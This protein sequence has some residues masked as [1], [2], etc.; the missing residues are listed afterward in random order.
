MEIMNKR[1]KPTSLL[2]ASSWL[3]I[4]SGGLSQWPRVGDNV[5][6]PPI[7]I[8][9]LQLLYRKLESVR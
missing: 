7:G 8:K 3:L 2:V 1:R 9:T 6:N 5:A 4:I